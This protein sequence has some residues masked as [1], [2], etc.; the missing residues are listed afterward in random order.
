MIVV[1]CMGERVDGLPAHEFLAREDIKL[2]VHAMISTDGTILR[3]RQDEQR[4]W[5]ATGYNDRALGVEILVPG[6]HDWD[7][8]VETIR[9]PWALSVQVDSAVW[10][11][12][13]W[14]TTWSIPLDQI[15]RHSDISDVK[16]DPGDGFD[17]STFRQRLVNNPS[18][19]TA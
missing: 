17:W 7:S 2:S 12:A 9:R 1:H 5:H 18:N 11:V 10:L 8:L 16:P 14:M 15:V 6:E 3:T 4:A 19:P 13:Q